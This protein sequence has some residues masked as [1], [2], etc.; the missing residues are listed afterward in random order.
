M[1]LQSGLFLGRLR[2]DSSLFN[3]VGSSAAFL[4]SGGGGIFGGIGGGIGGGVGLSKPENI[5]AYRRYFQGF[6]K[7]FVSSFIY[8]SKHREN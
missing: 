3:L 1:S 7:R 5:L 4:N 6:R 2:S 8:V